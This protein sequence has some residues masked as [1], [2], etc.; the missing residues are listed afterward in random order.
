MKLNKKFIIIIIAISVI[1]L[2]CGGFLIYTQLNNNPTN[3]NGNANNGEMSG[4]NEHSSWMDYLL[5]QNITSMKIVDCVNNNQNIY[6]ITTS[7]LKSIFQEMKK[8]T[9]V[10]DYDGGLGGICL[11][12]ITIEYKANNKTY[13]LDL[14]NNEYIDLEYL[15]DDKILSYLEQEK[16]TIKHESVNNTAK[17][18]IYTYNQDIVENIINTKRKNEPAKWVSYLLNQNIKE[19]KYY[20]GEMDENFNCA[21]AKTLT[22]TEL[23][24]ILTK[25]TETNLKKTNMTGLGGPCMSKIYI[26]YNNNKELNIYASEVIDASNTDSEII[27]LLEQEKYILDQYDDAPYDWYYIYSWDRTYIDTIVK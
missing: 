20:S 5:T 23:T 4:S 14:V 2:C 22:T 7:E 10:K 19:I 24:K 26:K 1:L 6:E 18:F 17:G 27:N 13:S 3:I 11:E 25:M 8:G 9:L 16:Y 12:H 21:E 15:K